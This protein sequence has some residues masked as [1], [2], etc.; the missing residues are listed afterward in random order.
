MHASVVLR[1][2]AHTHDK[3]DTFYSTVKELHG[4]VNKM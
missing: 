3:I 1:R 2:L 4:C